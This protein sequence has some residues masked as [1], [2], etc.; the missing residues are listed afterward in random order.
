MRKL[1]LGALEIFR[2][3]AREG[4]VTGAAASLNRVQSN[5]STRLKQLE[6]RLEA[7]L[8]VRG[9][10]GLALTEEGRTLLTYAERL[11]SLSDEAA[12]ALVRG[13]PTGS[14]RIGAMESTAAARLPAFLSRYHAE[15]P[16]V[17]IHLE[18]ATAGVLTE[19]LLAARID[20]AFIAEP[21]EIAGIRTQKVFTERLVL[22]TPANF[23][24][25]EKTE[26]ISGRTIV[27]FEEGCA[28]RRYLNDWLLAEGIVPGAIL[29]VGSYLAILACVSAGTG[30]AV[31][32]Q[33][34][35]DTVATTGAVRCHPLPGRLSRIKT[36][37][38]WQDGYASPKLAAL[39]TLMPS[40]LEP[41]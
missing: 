35:L 8:F 17:E 23:P 27:A 37:L 1:D 7:T 18:T 31:V 29:S 32:P 30:Y 33:S 19:K 4:S 5:V 36:L 24:A 38:A 13:K 41:T 10:R 3:V 15:Y 6:D 14:F 20:V 12:D 39:R 25:L 34:V 22:V 11:L 9:R 16:D 40:A 26:E 2:E 28:Y 21:L